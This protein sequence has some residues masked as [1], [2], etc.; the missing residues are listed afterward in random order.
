MPAP[1]PHKVHVRRQAS[2][3]QIAIAWAR[4]GSAGTP[5]QAHGCRS[6]PLPRF[7]LHRLSAS[8]RLVASLRPPSYC[9]PA[10]GHPAAGRPPYSNTASVA[11]CLPRAIPPPPLPPRRGEQQMAGVLSGDCRCDR[12]FAEFG[13]QQRMP[14]GRR[15][16]SLRAVHPP[17]AP[18][19][20]QSPAPRRT[21]TA[22]SS[23]SSHKSRLYLTVEDLQGT[24]SGGNSYIPNLTLHRSPAG[25]RLSGFGRVRRTPKVPLAASNTRSITSIRASCVPFRGASVS[26]VA[27]SPT[28]IVP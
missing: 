12:I 25:N 18:S 9:A 17:P 23:A 4:R 26:T 28:A 21:A 3:G 1:S 7:S 22:S 24:R 5:R 19:V 8:R 6:G 16:I 10:R 2:H 15:F 11:S 13:R 14:L 27:T 20:W